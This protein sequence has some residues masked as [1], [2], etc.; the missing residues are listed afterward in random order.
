MTMNADE[1]FRIEISEVE[2]VTVV[3]LNG[4]WDLSNKDRLHDALLSL[5]TK[6]D[7]VVDLRAASFFD[8]SS[9]GELIS[10]HNRLTAEGHR[11]EA[12]VGTSNMQRLLELTNLDTMFRI[13]PERAAF[14]T[15]R[16]PAPSSL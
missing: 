12:L 1:A 7:V 10:L 8:S 5:G 15:E 14:F 13:D 16:L 11:V 2:G 6:H 3:A 9:L 4:D